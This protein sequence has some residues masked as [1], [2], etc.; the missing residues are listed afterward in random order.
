MRKECP[1]EE[2]LA[3][4]I[5]E[6]ARDADVLHKYKKNIKQDAD[7]LSKVHSLLTS[8]YRELKRG[9]VEIA[10]NM[11]DENATQGIS[12]D[13]KQDEQDEVDLNEEIDKAYETIKGKE[14]QIY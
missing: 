3:G 11:G 4:Y 14:N 1:L 9:N 7:R 2:K 13:E 8:A 10:G 5:K 6:L 12:E